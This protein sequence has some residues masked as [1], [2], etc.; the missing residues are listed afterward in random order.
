MTELVPPT[1]DAA[2]LAARFAARA[3]ESGDADIA[4]ALVDSPAGLLVAARTPAGLVRLAYEDFNGGVDR[5]LEQL[6]ARLSPRIVEA[7]GRLDDTRRELDEY[8]TG[9][10]HDFDIPIDWRLTTPF[11]RRV[12]QATAQIP[13]GDTSTYAQIAAAAGSPKG[14]RPTGNALG[15]NPIPIIVPCHRVMA[16]GG[17]M[18][19]YTGG[20]SRKELLLGIE[21]VRLPS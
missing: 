3:A 13:F 10:R 18:G 14:A 20:L 5:V 21:G 12:L 4:Y 17:K 11:A 8:F 7:P 19:G 15:S 16:S 1:V 6:A 9:K 2:A